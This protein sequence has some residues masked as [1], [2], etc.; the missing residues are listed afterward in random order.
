MTRRDR[1]G[2]ALV[3]LALVLP[4][5]VGLAGVVI[6]LG[7]RLRAE[8]QFSAANAAVLRVAYRNERDEGQLRGLFLAT[9][10]VGEEVASLEVEVV[11][12]EAAFDDLPAVWVR[13]RYQAPALGVLPRALGPGALEARLGSPL[14]VEG[15]PGALWHG[16]DEEP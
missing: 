5:L 10:G 7:T 4:L 6:Q 11:P 1:S 16:E 2:Q 15:T 9:L 3:E 14:L 12:R 13:T 8:A